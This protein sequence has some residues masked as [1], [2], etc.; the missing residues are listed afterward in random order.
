LAL[1]GLLLFVQP[2]VRSLERHPK[3]PRQFLLQEREAPRLVPDLEIIHY[4]EDWLAEGRHEAF[5]LARRHLG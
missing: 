3:P 5:L 2:T 1:N 4:E